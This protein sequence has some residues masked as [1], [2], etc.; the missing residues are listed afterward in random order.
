MRL[1]PYIVILS[2]L[3]GS[4]VEAAKRNVYEW[5]AVAPVVVEGTNLGTYGKYA[6][7]RIDD[8]LRGE[9]AVGNVIRVNVRRANRDRNRQVDKDALRF[10]EQLSYLL[11]LTPVPTRRADAPP[12]FEFVR[13]ARGAREVPPE[14]RDAFLDAARRFVHIQDRND[15]LLTWR[16]MSDMLEETNPLLIQTALDQFLKFRRGDADLLGSLRPLLDHPSQLIREDSAL[17]IGQVLERHAGEPYPDRAALQSELV[18]RARGD[19]AVPVRVAATL[20]LGGFGEGAVDEI[21]EEIAREDPD[22]AVRYTAERLMH[23]REELRED[24]EPAE[25]EAADGAVRG[26][27]DPN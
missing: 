19:S 20:G 15:D 10:E 5:L 22:Q 6:E 13:G 27:G 17:L 11:L 3:S 18:A 25:S 26:R 8:V 21:L 9:G 16:E 4:T 23:E 12:T 2:L 14:G 7:F 1:V 24:A